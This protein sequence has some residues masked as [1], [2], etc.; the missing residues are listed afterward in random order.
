MWILLA[1]VVWLVVG[2]QTHSSPNVR[3][4]N[5][6]HT[7]H[8]PSAEST[9]IYLMLGTE[10][11]LDE[12]FQPGMAHFTEHLVWN[13]MHQ[14]GGDSYI[15]KSNAWTNSHG[16]AYWLSSS[17]EDLSDLLT[18]LFKVFQPISVPQSFANSERDIVLREYDRGLID[19]IDAQ[20]RESI[21][22]FLYD[23]NKKA[24]STLGTP[25]GIANFK[26]DRAVKFH[27]LTHRA[28]KATL[29]VVGDVTAQ[30]VRK[31]VAKTGLAALTG[32]VE[33]LVPVPFV[34]GSSE[35]QLF[36]FEDEAATARMV[37]RK[38]VKLDAAIDLDVLE[39]NLGLLE[40]ILD[41]NL[42]G[43]VAGPLRFERFVA[44]SFRLSLHAHDEQHIELWFDA[45]PDTD[46]SLE[47]LRDE[48]ES[49]LEQSA[50][51]I[52]LQTYNRVRSRFDTYWP[53]WNKPNQSAQWMSQYVL[54]R[55]GNLRQPLSKIELMALDKELSIDQV[56]ALLASLQGSGK[57]AVAF[58]NSKKRDSL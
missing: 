47:Q 10:N 27:T 54:N 22:Q 15:Q 11:T 13:N 45:L 52:E 18:S 58:I 31:A 46:V 51:G 57:L 53:D 39:S 35:T 56:N 16:M 49:V 6:I 3:Y 25:Q 7:V 42:P 9:S 21:N 33:E 29:V 30:Q 2:C 38:V 37:W 12:V 23:G 8:V 50:K 20:A 40:R 44:S 34:L 4:V 48:F 43:G 14:T 36:Q 17:S 24:Y 5:T 32:N 55:A 41:S 26:Y 28:D 1:C 19:N